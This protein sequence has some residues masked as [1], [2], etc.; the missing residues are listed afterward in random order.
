[1][2]DDEYDGDT[3]DHHR[4]REVEPRLR[5]VVSDPS[6]IVITGGTEASILI[7]FG[8]A[9]SI[10]WFLGNLQLGEHDIHTSYGIVMDIGFILGIF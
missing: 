4:R 1:V 10:R 9:A 8:E 2:G 6:W 7:L 3:A 5:N